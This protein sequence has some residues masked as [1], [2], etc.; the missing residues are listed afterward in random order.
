MAYMKDRGYLYSLVQEAPKPDDRIK[1]E[2][3]I[4]ELE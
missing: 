3:R 2:E 4:N 1:F